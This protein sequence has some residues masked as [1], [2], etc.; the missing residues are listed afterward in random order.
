VIGAVFFG[1]MGTGAEPAFGPAFGL[2]LEVLAGC[3]VVL[4]AL[5][6]LLP[7]GRRG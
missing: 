3:P 5:S 2:S 6:L 4:A 7:A 1:A